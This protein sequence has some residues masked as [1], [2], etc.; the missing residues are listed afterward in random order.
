[1]GLWELHCFACN[2]GIALDVTNNAVAGFMDEKTELTGQHLRLRLVTPE[3]AKFIHGLRTN[4][5]YNQYLS[6]V[7]GTAEDQRAWIDSYKTREAAGEEYYYIIERRDDGRPCGV[8]RLYDITGGRFT[9]GS[10]IL[11]ANKPPKAA[12]ESAVL[13]FAVGFERLGLHLAELDVRRANSRAIAFYHR[14]GMTETGQDAENLYFE[15][16][17][18]DF[19]KARGGFLAVIAEQTEN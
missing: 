17:R 10:W 5:V 12:L 16:S 13:S 3:D 1:M 7:T 11:N 4:P 2:S 18:D 14:F 6:Y 9:W 8:V 19:R 15:L